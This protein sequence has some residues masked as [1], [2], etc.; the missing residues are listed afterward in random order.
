MLVAFSD[1]H[2]TDGTA[3][4]SNLSADAVEKVL[5]EALISVLDRRPQVRE[6]RVAVLGDLFDLV[7]TRRWWEIKGGEWAERAVTPWSSGDERTLEEEAHGVMGEILERNRPF[8]QALRELPEKLLEEYPRLEQAELV[9]VVGNHDRLVGQLPSLRRLAQEELEAEVLWGRAYEPE[10]YELTASHGHQFDLVNRPDRGLPPLGDFIAS[11][12]T[13]LPWWV[14]ELVR[15][16]QRRGKLKGVDAAELRQR[17]LGVDDVRPLS[18]ALEW[19]MGQLRGD[20]ELEGFLEEALLDQMSRL[21]ENRFLK[22]WLKVHDEELGAR[23]EL[24]GLVGLL[25][26]HEA[27][28]WLGRRLFNLDRILRLLQALRRGDGDPYLEAA[29]REAAERGMRYVIMGHTHVPRMEILNADGALYLNCGTWRR[30]IHRAWD[31]SF[32]FIR[33]I[34]YLLVYAPEEHH[35]RFEL[36]QGLQAG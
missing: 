18:A 23:D 13:A 31:G 22:R 2:L 25:A 16:R 32:G 6:V 21:R 1:V 24:V 27:L 36:W 14:E 11:L 34:T 28:Q 17:L 33:H 35:R 4:P 8:V 12:I 30:R 29:R 26:S 7:R 15:D 5:L 3:F 9:Y 19:A 10:G 20:P